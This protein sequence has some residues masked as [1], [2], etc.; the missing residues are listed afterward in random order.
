MNK[1]LKF[2]IIGAAV[3]AGYS[4]AKSLSADASPAPEGESSPAALVGGLAAG[5]A[6]VGFVL[7]RRARRRHRNRSAIEALKAGDFALAARAARPMLEHA[8]EA[9]RP[10]LEHAVEAARPRLEHAAEVTRE[11]ASSAAERARPRV[12]HALE[13]AVEAARPRLE[14]AREAAMVRMDDAVARARKADAAPR[15]R[16]LITA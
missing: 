9:A 2:A 10:R 8:V 15:P 16:V 3:G 6:V 13:T 7:D 11:A 5:G 14:Q 4:A 12:E 1:T